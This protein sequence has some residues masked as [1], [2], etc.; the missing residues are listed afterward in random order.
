MS[1]YTGKSYEQAYKDRSS[2]YKNMSYE[3]Y[4]TEAER[5]NKIYKETGKW[6]VKKSYP[7]TLKDETKSNT[8]KKNKEVRVHN[9]PLNIKKD[10]DTPYRLDIL[11]GEGQLLAK[12]GGIKKARKARKAYRSN[13]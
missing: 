1:V 9:H 4:K 8:K 13:R 5:Q 11:P 2:R 7:N 10:L 12:R 3:A 6:D